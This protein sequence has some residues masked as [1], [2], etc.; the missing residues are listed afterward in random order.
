[1]LP[2][3]ARPS[4]P[5]F[6]L[7][8]GRRTPN[9]VLRVMQATLRPLVLGTL[10]VALPILLVFGLPSVV[11]G[12]FQYGPS[13]LLGLALAIFVII[14]LAVGAF[15]NVLTI[16][17]VAPTISMEI[18]LQSWRL[19]R[20]TLVS[21][22]DVLY[23]KLAAAGHLLRDQ[24]SALL[25]VRVISLITGLLLVLWMFVNE[26]LYYASRQDLLAFWYEGRAIPIVLAVLAGSLFWIAQPL[27]QMALNGS[28]A[29]LSSAMSRTRG[30]ALA[31]A[32]AGR[33]VLWITSIMLNGAAIFGLG[34]LILGNW[35]DP[36]YAPITAFR[37]LPEPTPA[38]A[39]W[40]VG[41]LI[42]TYALMVLA[43]QAGLTMLLLGLTERRARRLEV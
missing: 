29:L 36:R 7:E 40:V 30:Q 20:T 16:A 1:V 17:Q 15:A 33:L 6:Q 34:Y 35:L 28:L 12:D 39:T 13:T 42:A 27:L 26:A 41:G 14:Q 31:M 21:L 25:I 8:A 4:H 22:R 9:R 19:L 24:L 5:V 23:A 18:E 43:A 38:Q 37:S 32:L 2:A 11:L 3:W 10:S